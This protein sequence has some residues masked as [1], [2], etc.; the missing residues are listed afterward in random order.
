MLEKAGSSQHAPTLKR[1]QETMKI[2]PTSKTGGVLVELGPQ[3]SQ[4][5]SPFRS[6][7]VLPAFKLK[8]ILVPVDFSDCFK[9][10]LQYAIPFARQFDAELKLLH[11]VEPYPA[12]PEMG[13]VDVETLQVGRAQLEALRRAIGEAVPASTLLRTGVPNIEI[14]Q[15]AKE[16]G[17]DL[18]ILSTHGR[19]GLAHIL[20]GS[21]A[22]RVI[23]HAPCP[24]LVV[25]ERE[26]DFVADQPA[27]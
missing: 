16:L 25:R 12:V 21:T 8:K 6:P 2:K 3:E 5:P 14:V 4:L 19:T 20:L 26:H 15:A 17:I 11:V 1:E 22:E 13:P 23:R 7:E 9:K 10:A 27:Q 18:I 24:V